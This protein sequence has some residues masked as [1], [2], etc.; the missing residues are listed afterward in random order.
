VISVLSGI[1]IRRKIGEMVILGFAAAG[2]AYLFGRIAQ[3]YS[4]S[5]FEQTG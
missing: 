5:R 2:I 3:A 1:A 4:V